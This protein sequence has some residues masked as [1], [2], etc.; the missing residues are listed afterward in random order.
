MQK[1]AGAISKSQSMPLGLSVNRWNEY[2]P[3]Q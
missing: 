1:T 2:V 3:Y